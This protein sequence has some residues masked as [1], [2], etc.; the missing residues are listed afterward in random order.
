M[1]SIERSIL[2]AEIALT[3]GIGGTQAE[4]LIDRVMEKVRM[5]QFKP[6][7]AEQQASQA[8]RNQAE[9]EAMYARAFDLWERNFRCTPTQFMSEE[10][11]R[12]LDV[13]EVSVGRAEYFM[14]LLKHLNGVK[15]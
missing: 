14:A 12:A 5:L 13:D 7:T 9:M 4:A 15:P 1:L 11:T 10:E 6:L 8:R 3:T 2:V